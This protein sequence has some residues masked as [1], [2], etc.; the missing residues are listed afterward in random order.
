MP[1]PTRDAYGEEKP[2]YSYIALTAMAIKSSPNDQMSL[3]EIYQYIMDNFP[4]Y[5]KNHQRWQNSLRHNLSFN[6]CFV[7]VPRNDDQP[8]K[9]SLWTLHP[10][11]GE[12]F[13]NGSFL[14][15]RQRF[16]AP[17][18][19]QKETRKGVKETMD[20]FSPANL[21]ASIN[22]VERNFQNLPLFQTAPGPADYVSTKFYPNPLCRPLGAVFP[23]PSF[24]PHSFSS[25]S[26][27]ASA[28]VAAFR[29]HS[30]LNGI[31]NPIASF[32]PR[33]H[34]SPVS[35]GNIYGF[36]PLNSLQPLG[37]TSAF[38]NLQTNNKVSSCFSKKVTEH[39]AAD[40]EL[41][42]KSVLS[43]NKSV[44]KDF[45][46]QGK[47]LFDRK[48]DSKPLK[49]SIENIIND[50]VALKRKPDINAIN[51]ID[52]NKKRRSLPTE[53]KLKLSQQKQMQVVEAQKKSLA[54]TF[55]IYAGNPQ[56][57]FDLNATERSTNAPT[58]DNQSFT[59]KQL[60]TS[61]DRRQNDSPCCTSKEST[62]DSFKNEIPDSIS[63]T[64]DFGQ[65]VSAFA[66]LKRFTE[67]PVT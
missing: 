58:N 9:G 60:K 5:R 4:F 62:S 25:I 66:K 50:K 18:K 15:R 29:R 27:N 31:R 10:S 49:F 26:L 17:E 45:C 30:T 51:V 57:N 61:E 12:M 24:M 40:E 55:S 38:L 36:S 54:C 46:K 11:C 41:E 48:N 53:N 21:P 32:N 13:D 19:N 39:F 56:I 22:S 28:N 7:K 2:P 44:K 35:F 1:R 52:V 63:C 14:R 59:H 43:K 65:E 64:E 67:L 16:K 23:F 33:S 37:P 3:S 20:L 6:D 47:T 42:E 34:L 8:G